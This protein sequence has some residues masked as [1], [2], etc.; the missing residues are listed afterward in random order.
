MSLRRHG[1]LPKL[2]VPLWRVP[3][4]RIVVLLGVDIEVH[5]LLE[6]TTEF[7]RGAQP[8]PIR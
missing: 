3:I 1:D 4:I 2:D 8:T 6:T 7:P 5:L